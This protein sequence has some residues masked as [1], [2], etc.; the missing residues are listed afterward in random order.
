MELA[1]GPQGCELAQTL[2]GGLGPVF[3]DGLVDV[4]RDEVSQL[5]P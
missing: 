2:V 4:A 5:A 3:G 1:G